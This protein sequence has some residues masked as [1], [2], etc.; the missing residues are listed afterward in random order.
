MKNIDLK[1]I[2]TQLPH[3]AIQE[4][5]KQTRLSSSTISRVL[6]GDIKSHKQPEIIK[7]AAEVIASYKAREREA[8]T[9]ALEALELEY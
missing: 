5:A 9:V 3:G 7:A 2:R 1:Q 8:R 4:V 6:K